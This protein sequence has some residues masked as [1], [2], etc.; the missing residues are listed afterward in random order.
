MILVEF[1]YIENKGM[2]VICIALIG[3]ISICLFLNL[4]KNLLLHFVI[5]IV[6]LFSRIG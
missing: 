4:R 1:L 5:V 6:S 2:P 3:F